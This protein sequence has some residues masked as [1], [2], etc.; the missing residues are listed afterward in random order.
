MGWQAATLI[1]VNP[2]LRRRGEDTLAVCGTLPSAL[3]SAA[4]SDSMAKVSAGLLLYR[5][6]PALAV[7]LVH[8]GGPYW[9]KKDGGAWSIP[10]G[11]IDMDE[12]PLLAA[13]REFREETGFAVDGAFRMLDSVTLPGGKRLLAWAVAGDCDPADLVS[14]RFEMEW[15]PRSGRTLSFP[16][17]DRG[18]WFA[19]AA[20]LVKITKGQRPL[21]E[22]FFD[23]FG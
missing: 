1:L 7:F 6:R 22:R 4:R 9:A 5:R 17:A 13:R 18:E 10:K 14:N 15:P 8:P 12:D 23:E 11:L 16:E 2:Q 21:I 3:S 20:A 19:R